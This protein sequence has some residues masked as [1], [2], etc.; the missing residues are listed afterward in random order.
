MSIFSASFWKY[1][2][3]ISQQEIYEDRGNKDKGLGEH[4]KK[5]CKGLRNWLSI[6]IKE[7]AHVN[8]VTVE[9][10]PLKGSGV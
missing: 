6:I 1:Y 8:Y 10:T 5:S 4:R 7:N 3:K 2:S 9:V